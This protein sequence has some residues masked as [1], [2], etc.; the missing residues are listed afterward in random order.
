MNRG[1]V[2]QY[3]Q[4]T[5]PSFQEQLG[6]G[7]TFQGPVGGTFQDPVEGSAR[8]QSS[9]VSRGR[10]GGFNKGMGRGRKN[11]NHL[12][13][14]IP[15]LDEGRRDIGEMSARMNSIVLLLQRNSLFL[16]RQTCQ[17]LM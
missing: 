17:S 2:G 11:P 5:G 16:W 3:L 12:F 14:M 9:F 4:N 8:E 13:L 1:G 10:G 15:V 6:M 7:G